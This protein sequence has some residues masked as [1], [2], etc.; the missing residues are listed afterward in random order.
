MAAPTL[1]TSEYPNV[2]IRFQAEL[3]H[4][5]IAQH[6]ETFERLFTERGPFLT[7]ATLDQLRAS[8][9]TAK[10]RRALAESAD[11]LAS[12]GAFIAEFVVTQS[13]LLRGWFTAYSWLRSVGRNHPLSCFA[14]EA[15]ALTAARA[16]LSRY[17]SGLTP[18]R[19]PPSSD[20]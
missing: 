11:A 16:Y 15:E 4:E 8:H 3:T 5:D 12:R 18:R 19:P 13:T 17:N 14:T 10:H 2:W 6:H 7:I 9:F 1:D 20:A